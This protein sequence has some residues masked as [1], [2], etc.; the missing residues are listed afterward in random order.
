MC[1]NKHS[2][3][4]SCIKYV[5]KYSLGSLVRDQCCH[6]GGKV[7]DLDCWIAIAKVNLSGVSRVVN[8]D[9]GKL[10]SRIVSLIPLIFRPA[11]PPLVDVKAMSLPVHSSREEKKVDSRL[12]VVIRLNSSFICRA[13]R[14][15]ALSILTSS[16]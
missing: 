15:Q 2:N 14:R 9:Q 8:T 3:H 13:H 10:T 5:G 4:S 16:F 6:G 11:A 12:T 7:A 1:V